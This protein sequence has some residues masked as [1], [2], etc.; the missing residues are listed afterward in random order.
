MESEVV[1]LKMKVEL[2]E[3]KVAEQAFLLKECKMSSDKKYENKMPLDYNR[4][5]VDYSLLPVRKQYQTPKTCLEALTA[6]PSLKSG[7]FFIDPDGHGMGDE[8]IYVYC[9]M[10]TGKFLKKESRRSFIFF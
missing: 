5:K 9:N 4:E 10:T 2:L 3:T 7:M 8:P 6:D 1:K